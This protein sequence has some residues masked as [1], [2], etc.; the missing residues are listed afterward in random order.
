MAA[1][2]RADAILCVWCPD[3]K[4]EGQLTPPYPLYVEYTAAVFRKDVIR[5]WKGIET[6]N[7]TRAVGLRGY[8]YY[9]VGLLFQ[10]KPAIGPFCVSSS[11]R[12]AG[13]SMVYKR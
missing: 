11:I 4:A 2:R 9:T 8:D 13:P 3:I 5:T 7:N 1:S 10:D 12:Q 6:L